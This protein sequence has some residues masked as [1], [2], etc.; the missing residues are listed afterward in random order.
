MRSAL[1]KFASNKRQEGTPEEYKANVQGLLIR[2]EAS[3][4]K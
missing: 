3:K 2:V 1:P 4:A